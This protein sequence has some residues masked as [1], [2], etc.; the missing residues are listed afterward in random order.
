MS[1]SNAVDIKTIICLMCEGPFVEDKFILHRGC[2]EAAIE[3]G[4]IEKLDGH[5]DPWYDDRPFRVRELRGQ[6][7]TEQEYHDDFTP[8][9]DRLRD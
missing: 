4:L 3:A 9:I 8:I 1:K 2:A 7:V 5:Y 6:L